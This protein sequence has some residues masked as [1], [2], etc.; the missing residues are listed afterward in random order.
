[1]LAAAEVDLGEAAAIALAQRLGSELLIID[2]MAGRRLARRLGLAIT[3][4]VGIV[5]AAAES[6]L[7]EDPF[8]LLEE[9]RHRGGLW[10]SDA[11]LERLRSM[12]RSS[13]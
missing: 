4:T 9:L 8:I 1:M 13:S 2:D 12:Q 10:L 3:G 11:F 7:T 6:G 5:L